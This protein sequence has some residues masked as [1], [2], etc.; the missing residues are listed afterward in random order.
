MP[1]DGHGISYRRHL[2]RSAKFGAV[3]Q[4]RAFRNR[5]VV[6]P[7]MSA[8]TRDE[9]IVAVKAAIDTAA[10][11]EQAARGDDGAPTASA[12]TAAFEALWPLPKHQLL[13]LSAHA[14]AAHHIVSATQ[15]ANAAGWDD[16]SAANLHYG[17]LGYDVALEL[18]WT[19]AETSNGQP[20]WTFTL[21]T[22]APSQE[23]QATDPTLNPAHFQWKLRPQV[24]E[25]LGKLLA[26]D[27][28]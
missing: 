7:T 13:M 27:K 8:P 5:K 24:A 21:A 26:Q 12:Y 16:F 9:A 18:E 23:V 3:W 14:N 1:N 17:K 4:A 11:E 6:G 19:P 20:V 2:I 25:A 28:P 22:E 10:A 15:L